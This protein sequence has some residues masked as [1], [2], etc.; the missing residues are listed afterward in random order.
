VTGPAK[1]FESDTPRHEGDS[2]FLVGKR[3]NIGAQ[4]RSFEADLP[5]DSFSMIVAPGTLLP[6]DS[7][8]GRSPAWKR[9]A[10]RS[11][12]DARDARPC[13][14]NGPMVGIDWR[15]SPA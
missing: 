8:T 14:G 2:R 7:R 9:S 12:R 6:R 15:M 11:V 1:E 10:R 13:S 5:H 3:P 4:G